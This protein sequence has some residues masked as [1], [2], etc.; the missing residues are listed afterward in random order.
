MQRSHHDPRGR[1]AWAVLTVMLIVACPKRQDSEVPEP[2]AGAEGDAARA[3]G[4]AP[5][6]PGE[7]IL[8][9]TPVDEPIRLSWRERAFVDAEAFKKDNPIVYM[10]VKTAVPDDDDPDDP[11]FQAAVAQDPRSAAV[12]LARV[13]SPREPDEVRLAC[14]RQLP[15]TGGDWSD[16]AAELIRFEGDAAVRKEL[17][18]TMRFAAADAAVVGLRRALTDEEPELRAA[19]ARTAGSQPAAA[20]LEAEL[21][22]V[23]AGD[24]DWEVRVEAARALGRLKVAGAASALTA[25][26]DDRDWRVRREALVALDLIDHDQ[27]VANPRVQA[28]VRDRAPQV[29]AQAKKIL[30]GAA[31]A[32]A[33]VAPPRLAAPPPP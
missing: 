19:A 29:A 16:G 10:R 27:A 12:L 23:L 5:S 15:L 33:R 17:I 7:V 2:A 1:R 6:E 3:G 8:V 24:P 13:Q 30:R 26:L 18:L 9:G 31:A 28:A 21:S 14:A 11:A 22:A 32:P 20:A 4:G 25:A